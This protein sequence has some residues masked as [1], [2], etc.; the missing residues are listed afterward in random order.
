LEWIKLKTNVGTI[1]GKKNYNLDK[2]K[3]SYTYIVKYD[4]AIKLLKE[5][6]PYLIIESK[7][8]RAA[9]II[10]KYKNATPRTGRYSP[11][12]LELKNAFYNEF[13]VIK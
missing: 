3:D 6:I 8:K 7:K 1:K 13:M 10:E 4:E 5:L 11:K 9:L 2:H 12:M